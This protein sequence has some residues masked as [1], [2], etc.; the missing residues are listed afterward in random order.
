V[1]VEGGG[2]L[3]HVTTKTGKALAWVNDN[4][5]LEPWQWLGGGFGVEH[6]YIDNLVRGMVDE[7]DLVV[8]YGGQVYDCDNPFPDHSEDD[9]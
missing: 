4:V 3:Y 7:G 1:E 9:E 5:P 2:T 6:R 8:R